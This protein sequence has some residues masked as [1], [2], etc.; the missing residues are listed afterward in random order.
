MQ[1]LLKNDKELGTLY[2]PV[3]SQKQRK[4]YLAITIIW[5]LSAIFFWGWWLRPE[6]NLGTVR[7]V[8]I[9]MCLGWVYLM[10]LYFV[11]MLQFSRAPCGP[12]AEA[13]QYRVALIVTK[14]PSEPFSVL[15]R[16]LVAMIAQG[17]PHDNWLADEDP[18][19]ETIAWCD[20]HGVRISCRK[21]HPDYHRDSWPRRKRCKE[22]NLAYFY[23]HWGYRDYD[24]VV[25]FDT[26]HAPQPGYLE[27]MLRPFIDPKVGYVSAPS[28]C[29]N[30]AAESWAARTR[31]H[32]ESAFHGVLQTGFAGL[33]APLCI[34]SHFAVRTAALKSVGGL[35]PELA[36]DHS[37]SMLLS[38]GGWKGVHAIDAIAIGDGP[39]NVSDLAT[40]EFQ[41]SR[42]L[43]TLLLRDSAPYIRAMPPK[44]KFQFVLCQLWYPL[45]A[46][47]MVTLYILPVIAVIFDVRLTNVT[48]PAFIGHS[49]PNALILI[50]F[51]ICMKRDGFLRPIDSAILSLEK[52][53][54]MCLQWPWVLWGSMIAVRDWIAGDFINFRVTPK[55]EA[56]RHF[57]PTKV[58]CVYAALAIGC[59]LPA[60]LA[61]NLKSAQG[62]SILATINGLMYAGIVFAILK[63]H[64]RE[65]PMVHRSQWKSAG[66]SAALVFSMAVCAVGTLT[67][68]GR[69]SVHALT[70]GLEPF[71]ITKVRYAASGANSDGSSPLHL[72]FEL[73]WN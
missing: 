19:P 10:Q 66:M 69:E 70:I 24:I 29:A 34:G 45:Y 14:T 43:V 39:A 47:C 64:F 30:N 11:V 44:L 54:F 7:Y 5:V 8:M 6:H 25:Q 22:G 1:E 12:Y 73:G 67:L 36:E 52:G 41:W 49:V 28:I 58:I 71:H 55:G 38:A 33:L 68:H 63:H 13:G 48:Y 32:M 65:N 50:F 27:E 20:A 26:D 61:T 21:G 51:A 42:S 15:R 23:D 40:Q 56:A 57:F 16:T 4:K 3:L 35:G 2:K 53:I 59:L 72:T 17:Y 60:L 9:S 18:S 46:L 31:L 62:F 37:T